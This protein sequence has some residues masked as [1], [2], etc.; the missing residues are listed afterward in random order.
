MK[1]IDEFYNESCK[2][3]YLECQLFFEFNDFH[4]TLYV[5]DTTLYKLS[6]FSKLSRDEREEMIQYIH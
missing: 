4:S 1:Y 3:R 2:N 6:T 5:N